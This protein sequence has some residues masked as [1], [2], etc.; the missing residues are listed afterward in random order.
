[1]IAF[2]AAAAVMIACALLAL[3]PPL[4][5]RRKGE[6]SDRGAANVAL[7]RQAI[8]DN[9][10]DLRSG[11]ISRDQW[12]SARGE[13]ERRVVEESHATDGTQPV[14]A[15]SD[16]SPR[17]ALLLA[18]VLPVAAVALYIVV[19]EPLAISGRPPVAEQAA[20]HAVESEQML[21]MAESLAKRLN[22]SPEDGEGWMMLGRTYTYLGRLQDALNAFEQAMKRRPDDARLLADYAD[23]YAGTKGGG[24]LMGEPE[25]FIKR[26]LALDANQPKALALAGTIAFQKKDFAAAARHW[27]RALAVLPEDSGFGRQIAAGLAQAREALGQSQPKGAGPVA[28]RAPATAPAGP[29]VSGTVTI[30]PDL[31]KRTSP[32]DTLF[33]FARLPEGGGPPLAVVRA[34]VGDLPLKFKLDDSMAMSPEN[35]LSR[36]ARVVITARVTKSGGVVPQPGDLEGASKPVIPGA[37]DIAVLIDKAR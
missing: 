14:A 18:I 19:G 23:I 7:L 31:A 15:A 10:A 32:G 37:S 30:A 29:T 6:I 5:A 2:L 20:G 21:A 24:S 11:A 26:A 16:R 1:M 22:A 8:E 34:K 27:E 9:D 3:L 13:I 12:E 33:V 4:L 36:A 35:T 28:A 17:I 25:K